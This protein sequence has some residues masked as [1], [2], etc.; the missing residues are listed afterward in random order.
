MKKLK[1][2]L[3]ILS[4]AAV[5]VMSGCSSGRIPCPDVSGK[6]KFSPLAMFKRSEPTPQDQA[7]EG[8]DLGGRDM[9]FDKKGLL[10]KKGPKMPTKKKKS[11]FLGITL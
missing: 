6:K 10:K 1:T 2:F 3:G 7:N 8:R 5:L 4:L 9:E 11:G